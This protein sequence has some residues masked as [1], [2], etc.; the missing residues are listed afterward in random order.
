MGWGFP[1]GAQHQGHRPA[2]QPQRGQAEDGLELEEARWVK[3]LQPVPSAT[4]PALGNSLRG[5]RAGGKGRGW[6]EAVRGEGSLGHL[7]S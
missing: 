2:E 7:A 6:G 5:R 3:P 4:P 1:V